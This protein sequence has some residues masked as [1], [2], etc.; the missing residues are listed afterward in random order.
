MPTTAANWFIRARLK[1]RQLLLLVGLDEERNIH[2]TAESLGM[3][4]PA[5][6]KL[7]KELEEMLGVELFERLPRGMR[8]T[9]Y[10][11]VLIRHARMVLSN[12]R[13]AHEEIG[14]LQ[15]GLAGQVTVGTIMSPASS[16]IPQAIARVKAQHPHLRIG[17]RLETSDVLQPL[18]QQGKLDILVA[19]LFPDADNEGL[20][21]EPL[22]EEP[23]CAV[24]RARHPYLRMR[25]L[26]HAKIANDSWVVP[27][28]G[29][30]LRHRFDL[31]FREHGLEPPKNVVETFALPVIMQVLAQSDSLAVMPIEVASHLAQHGLL[32]VL[33]IDLSCKM[34]LYGIITRRE[35]LLSPGAQ[36]MLTALRETAQTLYAQ[37]PS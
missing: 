28:A 30:V 26:T 3:T 27:P 32:A 17:V 18:L 25:P 2:K 10:G 31:S 13:Q 36:I 23:V 1:M 4:Q 21:F 37:P 8:P 33:P 5:A 19:R 35:Y 12:L 15:A 14:A 34:D 7:L 9:W 11:E 20:Q 29:S 22:A 6:S 24:A 16:L